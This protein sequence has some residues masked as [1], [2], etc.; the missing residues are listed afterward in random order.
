MLFSDRGTPFGYRHMDGFGGHVSILVNAAGERVWAKWHFKTCQGIRNLMADHAVRL[1]GTDPDY[2]HRDLYE[3]I[4]RGDF[5]CWDVSVQVMTEPARLAWERRTGWNAFDLTKVWPHKDFACLP[6]GVLQLNRNPARRHAELEQ[7]A[8]S[9]A[10][11]VP[12]QG[13][14]RDDAG[15]SKDHGSQA[16]QLFRLLSADEQDRLTTN[17]ANAMAGVSQRDTL[18]RQIAQFTRADARYGAAV[19]RKLQ[20]KLGVEAV[21]VDKSSA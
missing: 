3:A 19:A 9:P 15:A 18:R 4:D 20:D 6:V 8:F 13:A 21:S 16:G 1:A 11:V 5:P 17:I 7:A 2:A 14:G 10:N 12:G